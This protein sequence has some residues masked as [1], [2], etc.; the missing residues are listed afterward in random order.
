MLSDQ[1]GRKIAFTEYGYRNADA[2]AAEPWK[3][4]GNTVNNKAQANAYEGFYESF[5]NADW[6][7]G[8][9]LW[10]WYGENNS[11]ERNEI[12]F[13]PQGKPAEEVIKK[14]YAPG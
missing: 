10:K 4:E 13:T 11:G 7:L 6:F 9:F 5:A 12:D 2:C 3:E 8:G 1:S 14:W